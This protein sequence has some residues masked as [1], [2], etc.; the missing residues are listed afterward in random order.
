MSHLFTKKEN[1]SLKI[2]VHSTYSMKP[3]YF[4]KNDKS[5]DCK[6]IHTWQVVYVELLMLVK[7][8]Y[9]LICA[10]ME[11]NPVIV[12]RNLTKRRRI[13]VGLLKTESSY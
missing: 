5:Q 6:K 1:Y 8:K 9:F 3:I 11:T 7:I 13:P 2:L 4:A 10:V 12:Y